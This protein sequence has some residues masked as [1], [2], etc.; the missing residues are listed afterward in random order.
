M[1]KNMKAKNGA[2]YMAIK[3]NVKVIPVGIHG[4]F[5]P[6]SKVYVNYGEPIDLSKYKNQKDK[7]DEAT[8]IIMEQIVML[9]KKED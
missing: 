3:S 9:T 2:A 7:L 5:K 6:F 8:E 1:K 4:T